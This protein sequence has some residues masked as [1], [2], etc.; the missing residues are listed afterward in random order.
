MTRASRVMNRQDYDA[1]SP[2][3]T[4]Q[5][6]SMAM[7]HVSAKAVL[8]PDAKSGLLLIFDTRGKHS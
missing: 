6:L 7:F 1:L 5:R 2:S 3:V 8:R 4:Y